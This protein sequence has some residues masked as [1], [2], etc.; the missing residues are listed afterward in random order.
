MAASAFQQLRFYIPY[1]WKFAVLRRPAP[2]IYGIAITDRCNLACEGCRVSNTGRPDMTWRQIA[3]AMTGA[4]A[5]GYR[6]LYLTGGEPTLWRDGSR[7]M[8]DI[9]TEAY[10]LGFF[11]VHVYTN[12]LQGLSTSADLVWVSMDGLPASFEAR[13]GPRFSDVERAIRAR[14]HPRVA[15]IYTIDRRTAAGIGPFLRWVRDTAFPVMGVMFYFHTPYYGRDALFLA[16]DER[17]PIIDDLIGHIRDGLPVLN[18]RSGLRA[19]QS[20]NWPR[21]LQLAR[22]A[23]LDGEWP[24][25]R[26][27][28][29]PGDVCADC[30]YAAC[31]ELAELQ[32]LRPSA[33]LGMMRYW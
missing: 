16:A 10:R 9:V 12:G 6:D 28:A 30:G 3:D 27:S 21:P 18:S 8:E 32:R 14:A 1:A 15:L 29:A 33:A 23:D 19:L 31:T 5:R 24:C 26:A 22:V 11:H 7:S 4:F 13:R 20:G 17:A 2:L 25:C